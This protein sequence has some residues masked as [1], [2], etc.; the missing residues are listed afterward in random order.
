MRQELENRVT[1]LHVYDVI[2]DIDRS[3]VSVDDG[4]RIRFVVWFDNK[5]RRLYTDYR[6]ALRIFYRY[7]S[8]FNRADF[9]IEKEREYKRYT[10]RMKRHFYKYEGN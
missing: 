4:I 1:S 6:A 10:I 9:L 8:N 2:D 5:C 7:R 3:N